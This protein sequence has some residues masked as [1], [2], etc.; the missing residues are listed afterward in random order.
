M[1]REATEA[2]ALSESASNEA[3]NAAAVAAE[4]KERAREAQMEAVFGRREAQMEAVFDRSF[5]RAFTLDDGV[6]RRFVDISRANLI[7]QTIVNF[8]A[9]LESIEGNVK[10]G[11]RA[12]IGALLAGLVM[13]LFK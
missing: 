11:V 3:V 8:D 10:W 2:A 9:R 5:K 6:T 13:L 4:A 12:V 7:C 1:E